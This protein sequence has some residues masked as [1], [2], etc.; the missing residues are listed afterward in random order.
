MNCLDCQ[1]LLSEYI[2]GDLK[3]NKRLLVSDH[4]KDCQECSLTHQDLKQIVGISQQLPLLVPKTALWKNIEKEIKELSLP[5]PPKTQS[6][7]SKFW[8]QRFQFSISMPQLTGTLA[9]LA[10]LVLLAS[11]FVY[12]PQNL[13]STPSQ[14]TVIAKPITYI[15]NTTEMELTSTIDRLS[16]TITERYKDWDPQVQKLY[17]RNLAAIDQSIEECSQLAQKNPSD[18][19]VHELMVTA[20]QEKIRLL[21]QFLSL[22]K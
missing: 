10:T 6:A 11:N 1:D 9:G 17:D 8:N 7:W 14:G 21:E 20:Y 22:H 4:L 12:S 19:I 15:S 2:D 16:H 5:T 3:P 13:A 18:P